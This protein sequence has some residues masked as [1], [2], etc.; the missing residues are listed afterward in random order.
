M[1]ARR[2]APVNL[3]E[4][5]TAAWRRAAQNA[6]QYRLNAVQVVT[7]LEIRALPRVALLPKLRTNEQSDATGSRR[8]KER[9]RKLQGTD[10]SHAVRTRLRNW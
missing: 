4:A 9:V 2:I 8:R 7:G 5:G 10:G 1:V 3:P 6:A